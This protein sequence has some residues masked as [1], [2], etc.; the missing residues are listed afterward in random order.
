MLRVGQPWCLCV[1]RTVH[2][3]TCGKRVSNH[4]SSVNA[5]LEI[6]LS[7]TVVARASV[8]A[9][10]NVTVACVLEVIVPIVKETAHPR[11]IT[12]R[13]LFSHSLT[14]TLISQHDAGD[15][16]TDRRTHTP[17]MVTFVT[18]ANL[19][20]TLETTGCFVEHVNFYHLFY[21]LFSNGSP[22]PLQAS[23]R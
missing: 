15:E 18:S 1:H 20:Q 10:A 5:W 16:I 12:R 14:H 2:L 8:I 21:P 7:I 9:V 19:S 23:S 3:F 6:R 17:G 13:F 11:P 22:A 4:H